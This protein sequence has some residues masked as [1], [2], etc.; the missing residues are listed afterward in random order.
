[1]QQAKCKISRRLGTNLFPKC[2]KVFARRPYPPGLKKKKPSRQLS[3]YGKEV[4]E[5]Q[6]LKYLYNLREKQFG[7]YVKK[8]LAVRGGT[9]DAA[10]SLIQLL[11]LRLDNAIFRLGFASTRQQARQMVSHGHFL[12]N[13]TRTTT[14]SYH[15]RKG[16]VVSLRSQSKNKTL[17]K[18]LGSRLKGF[19][20]PAWLELDKANFTAKVTGDPSLVEATP[21]V[22]MSAIFEFYSR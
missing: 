14:P 10:Q 2:E 16:D 21:P 8:I 17:F 6:K 1:M 13:D 4:R 7:N 18:D 15:L 22:E 5:K 11:E 19:Q 20:P 9:A 3:E 12:V